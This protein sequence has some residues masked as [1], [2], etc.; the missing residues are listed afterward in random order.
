MN[1]ADAHVYLRYLAGDYNDRLGATVTGALLDDAA[2]AY[3]VKNRS[4]ELHL[5]GAWSTAVGVGSALVSNPTYVVEVLAVYRETSNNTYFSGPEL[6]RLPLEQ[7]IKKQNDDPAQG[8]PRM[9]CPQP[10]DL[11]AAATST[12]P[13]SWRLWVWPIPDA[14]Y[15]YSLRHLRSM[16]YFDSVGATATSHNEAYA[17]VRN[18]AALGA[19]LLGRTDEVVEWIKRSTLET[20]R[21]GV[22]NARKA[23]VRRNKPR[24]LV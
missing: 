11:N 21:L 12:T 19:R 17:I 9:C 18:A 4:A 8:T 23:L 6:E 13:I 10:I 2:R 7:I 15:W 24:E 14:T 5:A 1:V 20:T 22:M 3:Y 16:A